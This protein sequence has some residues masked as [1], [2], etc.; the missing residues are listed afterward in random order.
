MMFSELSDLNCFPA[1]QNHLSLIS[2]I[3]G[4]DRVCQLVGE[5]NRQRPQIGN[6]RLHQDESLSQR[7]A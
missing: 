1:K 4:R 3:F 5:R 6:R 7:N 2:G